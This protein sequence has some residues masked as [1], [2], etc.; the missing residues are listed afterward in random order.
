MNV[1]KRCT[2]NDMIQTFDNIMRNFRHYCVGNSDLDEN[3]TGIADN[4]NIL[5]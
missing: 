2:I 4:A 5:W 3:S 1:V